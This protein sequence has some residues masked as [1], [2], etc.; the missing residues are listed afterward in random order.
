VLNSGERVPIR[1]AVVG[2]EW[3]ITS[4]RGPAYERDAR[5]PAEAQPRDYGAEFELQH[6]VEI[7]ANSLDPYQLLTDSVLPVDGPPIVR[8]DGVV[9]SGNGRTQSI[10]LAIGRGTYDHVREGILDRA[11]HFNFDPIE[12]A[13]HGAPVL[14]RI[15]QELVDDADELA[16]YGLEMN[17]DPGQG[18]SLS[19][20]S[21][22]LARLMTPAIVD[23]LI[24][25]VESLPDG[26]STREFM[27]IRAK[28]IAAIL[29]RGGLVDPRK[30]AVYFTPQ[31]D[32]TEAA[33]DLV[34]TTLAGLT[35][36]ETDVI[37]AASRAVRDRLVRTGIEFARAKAAGAAWDLTP[38]NNEAVRV[39]SEAEERS[40]YLRTLRAPL[41]DETGS[42][43]DK[44]LHP[45]RYEGAAEE[46]GFSP[47]KS[48]HPASEALARALELSPRDYVTCIRQFAS[49]AQ[50]GWHSMFE[51]VH[52]AEVFS[53]VI[54][55]RWD[56]TVQKEQW[57]DAR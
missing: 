24:R 28:D 44:L 53:R 14:V 21:V 22:S 50:G 43:V 42:L 35:V 3:L 33:K 51:C 27:R 36:T 11:T 9:I 56:L 17:R 20:Q 48:V 2:A 31:G 12:A 45:E 13:K 46:L 10:R 38:W 40:W 52:P 4:H 1:Y 29:S 19:E 26:C 54:G 32:L 5:Y 55:S 57:L 47:P 49:R 37:R 15:M 41:R 18:L 8:P 16:R 34:E 6:A 23:D 30:R 7:R 25:L 39:I